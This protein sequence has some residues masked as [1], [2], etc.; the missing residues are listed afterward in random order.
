MFFWE[1]FPLRHDFT[2]PCVDAAEFV[3]VGVAHVV[4]FLRRLLAAVADPAIDEDN[5]VQVGQFFSFSHF[6]INV[7]IKYKTAE[8]HLIREFPPLELFET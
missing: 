8:I 6:L 5:L 2:C 4:E 7:V 1:F 3:D